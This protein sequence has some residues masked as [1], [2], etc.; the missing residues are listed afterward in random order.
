MLPTV[1]IMPCALLGNTVPVMG[2]ADVG[3]DHMTSYSV[4]VT[5]V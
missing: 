2:A 5:T 4:K 3:R 1:L